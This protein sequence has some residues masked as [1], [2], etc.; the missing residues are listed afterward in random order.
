MWPITGEV[1][2]NGYVEES[3]LTLIYIQKSYL[4]LT[5]DISGQFCLIC[6]NSLHCFISKLE[7]VRR[8]ENKSTSSLL[9]LLSPLYPY[10]QFFL[11]LFLT[12]FITIVISVVMYLHNCLCFFLNF[13]FRMQSG[14]VLCMVRTKTFS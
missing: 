5:S 4:E 3:P 12:I 10:K 7:I 6:S 11:I 13:R 2:W 8:K 9:L 1:F 14:Q